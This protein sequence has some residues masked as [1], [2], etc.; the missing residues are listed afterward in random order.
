MIEMRWFIE[1]SQRIC[2]HTTLSLDPR[3]FSIYIPL[4]LIKHFWRETLILW[5]VL[6]PYGMVYIILVVSYPYSSLIINYLLY[7]NIFP[8][9]EKQGSDI[10]ERISESRRL[11][12]E[13]AVEDLHQDLNLL[14]NVS[15]C[16]PVLIK[17]SQ[18]KN[19]SLDD[20]CID[21][22]NTNISIFQIVGLVLTEVKGLWLWKTLRCC[23]HYQPLNVSWWIYHGAYVPQFWMEAKGHLMS[24]RCKSRWQL[25][26]WIQSFHVPLFL[27]RSE[28][29]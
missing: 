2:I 22:K 16:C 24:L 8:D 1:S 23:M 26:L 12:H 5:L 25:C 27:C 9:V 7:A 19:E 21:K 17:I 4:K 15:K 10:I 29:K 14:A 20:G 6:N 18:N 3:E 13:T 28:T 11:R